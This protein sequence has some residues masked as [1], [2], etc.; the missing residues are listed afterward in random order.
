MVSIG[1]TCRIRK[2][3]SSQCCEVRE[4]SALQQ[5]CLASNMAIDSHR[6]LLLCALSQN[7]P[8]KAL[9]VAQDMSEKTRLEPMTA[10]LVFKAALQAEDS[11]RAA[12]SLRVISMAPS[13][14]EYLSACVATS[15]RAGNI[16]F[17]IASMKK[18]FEKFEY[19]APNPVHLPALLRCMIRLSHNL[20]ESEQFRAEGQNFVQDL[21][22]L[23]D[24]GK[25][26]SVHISHETLT[27]SL[28]KPLQRLREIHATN[29]ETDCSTRTSLTGSVEPL[30]T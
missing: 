20:L 7:D 24:A 23:F 28:G 25:T 19:T 29:K 18:L 27:E 22:D 9:L 4:V 1:F 17:A 3:W 12:E 15:Q 13:P 2:F 8:D 6:K 11:Q 16:I 10:Y 14:Q 30:I 21:C 26:F 5:L